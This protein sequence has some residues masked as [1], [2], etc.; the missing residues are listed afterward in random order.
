MRR[1]LR[2]RLTQHHP[3]LPDI[4][5]MDKDQADKENLIDAAK[6]M[7]RNAT[8]TEALAVRLPGMPAS[9]LVAVGSPGSI[10]RLLESEVRPDPDPVEPDTDLLDTSADDMAQVAYLAACEASGQPALAWDKQNKF[11]KEVWRTTALAIS[12][13]TA[14]VCAELADQHE[15]ADEREIGAAIR[16]RYDL[17]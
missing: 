12:R 15:S 7:L 3:E 14:T 1:K 9:A 2:R 11:A 10:R 4:E 5:A 6:A 13:L 17:D 16:S 8:G